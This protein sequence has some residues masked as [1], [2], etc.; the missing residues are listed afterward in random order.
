MGITYIPPTVNQADRIKIKDLENNY[1]SATVEGALS[2]SA[3]KQSEMTVKIENAK[4]DDTELKRKTQTMQ[5]DIDSLV[6]H[7]GNP[8][9][10]SA[11][12]TQARGT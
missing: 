5:Q 6:L 2:E 4:Y 3:R 12:I 8:E 10:S 1:D 9:S 11:E 7:A